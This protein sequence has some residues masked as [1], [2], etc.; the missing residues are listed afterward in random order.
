VVTFDYDDYDQFVVKHWEF[1]KSFY[2]GY[3]PG[4]GYKTF[5]LYKKK[6]SE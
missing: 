2:N 6:K 1:V 5:N 4:E 3:F